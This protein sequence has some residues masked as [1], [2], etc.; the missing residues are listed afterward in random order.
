ML[1]VDRKT[2]YVR[3]RRRIDLFGKDVQILYLPDLTMDWHLKSRQKDQRSAFDFDM[4]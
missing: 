4:L 1:K 3:V 2:E